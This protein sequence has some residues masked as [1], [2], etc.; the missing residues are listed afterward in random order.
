MQPENFTSVGGAPAPSIN[1]PPGAYHQQADGKQTPLENV[2]KEAERAAARS[3]EIRRRLVAIGERIVG[4]GPQPPGGERQ[5]GEAIS[6][7]GFIPGTAVAMDR[8]HAEL[9]GIED[10]LLAFE[11]TV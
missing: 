10:L 8:L 7:S 3:S 4:P 5:A 2:R 9:S 1:R 6:Q 11:Q